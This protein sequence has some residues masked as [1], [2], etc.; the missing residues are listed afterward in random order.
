MNLS[1]DVD[2]ELCTAYED[3]FAEWASSE[4]AALWAQVSAD[5]LT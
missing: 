2:A 3:V 1:P 5:G 4:D